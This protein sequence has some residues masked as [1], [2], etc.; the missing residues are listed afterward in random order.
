MLAAWCAVSMRA[1]SMGVSVKDTN[2]ESS[3]ANATVRPN[4]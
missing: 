4:S 2:S 1:E 3:T